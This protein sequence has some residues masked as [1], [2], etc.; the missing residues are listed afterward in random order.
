MGHHVDTPDRGP[1]IV[2]G[3]DSHS[4]ADSGVRAEQIDGPGVGF[5]PDTAGVRPDGTGMGLGG[6]RDRLAR[7]EGS[8]VVE[9]APGEGTAL[10][11]T[12]PGTVPAGAA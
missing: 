6:M 8:L 11:A 5:D 3:I 10:V 1:K 4:G 12:L 9:S 7:I 2:V